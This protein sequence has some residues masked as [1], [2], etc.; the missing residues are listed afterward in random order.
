REIEACD[1]ER[2]LVGFEHRLKGLDRLK[3][4]V[5]VDVAEKGRTATDALS[6]VKDAIRFTFVYTDE[7]YGEGVRSDINHLEKRGFRQTECRN[8][9]TGESYKGINSRW[10][11]PETRQ[12]FEVQ[13]HTEASYEAKQL[14]HSAYERA[15]DPNTGRAEL[16]ELRE[17][18][19]DLCG[20]LAT[21]RGATDI[22]DYSMEDK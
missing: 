6:V 8:T 21:P 7:R 3:D 15:R 11:D 17:V 22:P 12:L 9:W 19:K 5:A 14:T 4:K 18:Q 10:W 2:R 13:F 1:P 20:R 16:R